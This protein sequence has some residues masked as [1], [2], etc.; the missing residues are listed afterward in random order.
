MTI[1][2]L[3]PGKIIYDVSFESFIWYEYVCPMPVKNPKNSGQYFIF[4]DKRVE[5]PVRLYKRDVQRILN[6]GIFNLKDCL[7]KQ[8]ELA[9]NHVKFLKTRIELNSI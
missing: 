1:E 5:K 3:T 2:E 8:L 7:I 9:E 6:G 4:I